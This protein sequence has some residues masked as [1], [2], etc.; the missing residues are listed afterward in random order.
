M[1]LNWKLD[2]NQQLFNDKRLFPLRLVLI[3]AQVISNYAVNISRLLFPLNPLTH[4]LTPFENKA[5]VCITSNRVN[6]VIFV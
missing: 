5:T 4:I 2:T 6:S 1:G 3:Q